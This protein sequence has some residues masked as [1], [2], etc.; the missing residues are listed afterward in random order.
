MQLII[1]DNFGLFLYKLVTILD[2]QYLFAHGVIKIE[3]PTPPQ[4]RECFQDL[5]A[6]HE[7]VTLPNLYWI[8]HTFFFKQVYIQ[9]ANDRSYS[10]QLNLN[11]SMATNEFCTTKH[12]NVT[13][14]TRWNGGHLFLSSKHEKGRWKSRPICNTSSGR[15]LFAYQRHWKPRQQLESGIAGSRRECKRKRSTERGGRIWT[16]NPLIRSPTPYQLSHWDRGAR[17]PEKNRTDVFSSFSTVSLSRFG[18][19]FAFQRHRNPRQQRKDTTSWIWKEMWKRKL[20]RDLNHRP[21]D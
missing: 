15:S 11:G 10:P 21:L 12:E 13:S 19:F 20:V 18:S 1:W 5:A 17:S 7:T 14:K 9:A 4:D 3:T 8:E 2:P 6:N 16:T